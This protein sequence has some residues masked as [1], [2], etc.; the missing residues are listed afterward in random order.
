MAARDRP[1]ADAI[2]AAVH[3]FDP[4]L[5]LFG[6]AASAL[7]A[8]GSAIGLHVAHEAFADRRYRSDGSLTPRSE[9]DAVIDDV[10][11]AVAQVVRIV[12]TGSVETGD[13]GTLAIR[14]DT[15][16]VHGDRPDAAQFARRLRQAL[17]AEGVTLRAL[18]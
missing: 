16:C 6:L 17:E 12:T 8:A 9:A 5:V 7:T 14:A 10:D 13:G 3:A 1:L 2:A 18:R 11:A 15:I 4:D